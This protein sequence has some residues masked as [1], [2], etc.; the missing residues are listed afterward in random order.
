MLPGLAYFL[1]ILYVFVC[2][3][4]ASCQDQEETRRLVDKALQEVAQSIHLSEDKIKVLTQEVAALHQDRDSLINA[5]AENMQQQSKVSEQLAVDEQKL[6]NYT[7][8]QQISQKKLKKVSKNFSSV[9]SALVNVGLDP[10][11]A[12]L[13]KP[14]DMQLMVRGADLL[15]FMLPRLQA[16]VSQVQKA[17]QQATVNMKATLA[18]KQAFAHDL[19]QQAVIRKKMQLLV[20]QKEQS[21]R[22]ATLSLDKTMQTKT[23]LAQKFNNLQD[24][25]DHI[26]T[27]Q[28]KEANI[29]KLKASEEKLYSSI[30]FEKLKGKLVLPMAGKIH[31]SEDVG[32]EYA[33]QGQTITAYKSGG[34]VY[35]PCNAVVLYAGLFRS[36]G[37]VVILEV[38][39]NYYI[40][41]SGFKNL[42]VKAG[43]F[44]NTKEQLGNVGG[45]NDLYIEFRQGNTPIAC[46][47]WWAK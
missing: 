44:V 7:Q 36:Y 27:S 12:L 15:S 45:G 31:L 13:I 33:A 21:E 25:F 28:D 30:A 43:Q 11:P 35:A 18:Q 22:S 14:E 10:P 40:V 2:I 47:G 1:S 39:R 17:L 23:I 9:I 41:M 29:I 6:R 5:I 24:L 42:Y 19:E 46:L 3:A 16:Q 32:V 4:P 37:N 34:A 20:E 8:Q 26:Q 38:G